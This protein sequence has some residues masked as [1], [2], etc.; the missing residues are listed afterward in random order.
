[1]NFPKVFAWPSAYLPLLMSL[2]AL[3]LVL[4]RVAVYGAVR[5]QDEG[6]AAH[7]FQ[8]LVVGQVPLIVFFAIKW[9]PRAPRFSLPVLALQAMAAMAALAS[10]AC[11]KL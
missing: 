3:A 1:M 8:L 4:V 10:V 6:A 5:D 7:V 2:A 11:F 9:L